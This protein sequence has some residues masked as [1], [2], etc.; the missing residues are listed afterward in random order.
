MESIKGSFLPGATQMDD[1]GEG[2]LQRGRAGWSEGEGTRE[3]GRG[4]TVKASAAVSFCVP[5]E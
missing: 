3:A 1:R 5:R 4:R 2:V